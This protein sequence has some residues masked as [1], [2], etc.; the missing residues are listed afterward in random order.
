M[1]LHCIIQFKASMK[2]F[3]GFWLNTDLITQ[4][5]KNVMSD[6][7]QGSIYSCKARMSQVLCT[8]QNYWFLCPVARG[9]F[10]THI[11]YK[12]IILNKREA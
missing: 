5:A 6:I 11:T 2:C 3:Y 12:H 8:C 7:A 4:L 9:K 1:L 10:N